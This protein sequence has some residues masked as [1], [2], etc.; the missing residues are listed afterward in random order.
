[1]YIETKELVCGYDNK[2]VTPPIS[3]NLG[4]GD[5][6]CIPWSNGVGKTT[7]FKTLQGFLKPV[8]GNVYLDGRPI[9]QW[10][11]KELAKQIAYVPQTQSQPFAYKVLDVVCMGR[12]VHMNPFSNPHKKGL[13]K[14]RQS[15]KTPY[16]G[17]EE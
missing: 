10:E 1:M 12:T 4:Q 2:A 9:S 8:G 13:H 17:S 6:T 3:I 14:M 11:R 7:F 5:I 15:W 16:F